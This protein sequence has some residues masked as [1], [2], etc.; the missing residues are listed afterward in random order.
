MCKSRS[1]ILRLVLGCVI[2]ITLFAMLEGNQSFAQ[3][4]RYIDESGNIHWVDR[5][6]DVPYRYRDQVVPPTAI[7]VYPKGFHP[8]PT[9]KP[10]ATPRPKK[11]PPQRPDFR[12]GPGSAGKPLPRGQQQYPNFPGQPDQ[13]PAPYPGGQGGA[14]NGVPPGYPAQQG[15]PNPQNQNY[16]PPPNSGFAPGGQQGEL[17]PPG[18]PPGAQAAAPPDAPPNLPQG[19]AQV[20]ANLQGAPPPPPVLR[21]EQSSAASSS[22]SMVSF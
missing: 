13:A 11:R 16:Q 6:D 2:S 3:V 5:L 12:R 15:Y 14:V 7:P 21:Q 20:P 22:N 18:A 9:R 4:Y 17:L 1:Q 19:E 10:T 8:K